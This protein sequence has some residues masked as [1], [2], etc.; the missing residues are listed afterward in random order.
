MK[1]LLL[2]LLFSSISYG[3]NA[4]SSIVA[5]DKIHLMNERV[6]HYSGHFGK[7]RMSGHLITDSLDNPISDSKYCQLENN[8]Q[9]FFYQLTT[10][11]RNGSIKYDSIID[12]RNH[13]RLKMKVVE[14]GIDGRKK[15]VLKL[16]SSIKLAPNEKI[17]NDKVLWNG[18]EKIL[19]PAKSKTTYR[20]FT[21]KDLRKLKSV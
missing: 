7:L 10:Y 16:R 19:Q 3:Q 14:N 9:I 15:R 4:D 11:H 21:L 20:D 6:M 18:V 8:P 5:L 2:F 12:F 1:A 13:K 17:S